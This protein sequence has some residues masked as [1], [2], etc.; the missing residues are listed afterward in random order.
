MHCLYC[1][2]RI[3]LSDEPYCDTGCAL[4]ARTSRRAES[5]LPAQHRETLQALLDDRAVSRE[6]AA[7]FFGWI[8]RPLAA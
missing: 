4:A 6:A 2:S 7:G 8:T 1:G 3:S 5:S